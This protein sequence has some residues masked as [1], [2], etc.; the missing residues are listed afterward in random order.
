[1]N[2]DSILGLRVKARR[3]FRKVITKVH[4]EHAVT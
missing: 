1:M 4:V 2:E 3:P